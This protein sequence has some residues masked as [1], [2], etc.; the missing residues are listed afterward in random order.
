M[1]PA[2]TGSGTSTN[3]IGTVR[4]ARRNGSIAALPDV[5]MTS[6]VSATSFRRVFASVIFT[7]SGPTIVDLDVLPDGPTQLLQSLQKRCVAVLHLGI[8]RAVG[9]ERGHAPHGRGLALLRAC[10]ERPSGG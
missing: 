1:K 8:V 5:K 2:P 6:G 4:V 9:H 7:A 3:T 10:A